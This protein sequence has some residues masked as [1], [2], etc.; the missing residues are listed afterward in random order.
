MLIQEHGH[1]AFDFFLN[2]S[3]VHLKEGHYN[4]IL[5]FLKEQ[6]SCL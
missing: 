4:V 5:T 2:V 3:G 6:N 1:T